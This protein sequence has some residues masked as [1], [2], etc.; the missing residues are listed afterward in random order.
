MLIDWKKYFWFY[1]ALWLW[2]TLS[3][4]NQQVWLLCATI[5]TIASMC[6][7]C[8][9]GAGG[10]NFPE[11]Q[12]SSSTEKVAE[13]S[14][15][16]VKNKL[17]CF[18]TQNNGSRTICKYLVKAIQLFKN[19]EITHIHLLGPF[20]RLVCL[21]SVCPI[22][23]PSPFPFSLTSVSVVEQTTVSAFR[24]LWSHTALLELSYGLR[25]TGRHTGSSVL[26]CSP[27][28][29]FD[30]TGCQ[31]PSFVPVLRLLLVTL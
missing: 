8:P 11:D 10:L 4:R 16:S 29:S 15:T 23:H 26:L 27:R 18:E 13:N 2:E 22:S 24:A 6:D 30:E 28:H 3:H 31:E 20:Q 12:R 21:H 14:R 25:I 1:S 5:T 9:T 17:K 7:L 19:I